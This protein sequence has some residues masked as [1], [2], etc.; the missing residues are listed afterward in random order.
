MVFEEL[1]GELRDERKRDDKKVY[2]RL[3][4]L[5][6]KLHKYTLHAGQDFVQERDTRTPYTVAGKCC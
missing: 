4:L 2:E 3:F 6:K 1:A 5:G